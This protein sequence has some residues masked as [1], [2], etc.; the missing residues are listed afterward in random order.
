[1]RQPGT[2]Y[3]IVEIKD[4]RL[5]SAL[6]IRMSTELQVESPEDQEREIRAYAERYGIEIVKTY[7]DLGVSGMTAEKREQFQALLDDVE[8]GRNNYSIVLYLDDSR[9]GRFVDS[10][11]ADY[12][13]MKLE[14]NGVIC[15]ACDKPLTMTTTI[16]DR[17]MTMLNDE[18]ASDY[19]RQLSQKFLLVSATSSSRA[20][21]K[22]AR[23]VWD[24]PH[25]IDR[26]R[27]AQAGIDHGAAQEPSDGTGC[28][29]PRPTAGAGQ[30]CL[31]V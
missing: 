18:S 8:Y 16:A 27:R 1:M 22:E 17:I 10:R 5:K 29:D 19:C 30:G 12:Y 13:R 9:W 25:V 7:A 21:A 11:D 6:Y 20:T 23:R 24:S 3:T 4:M 26:G 28:A 15:Q 2:P 14:R 31:D